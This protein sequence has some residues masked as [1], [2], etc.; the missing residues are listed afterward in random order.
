MNETQNIFTKRRR[1]NFHIVPNIADDELDLYEYRLYGHYVRVCGEQSAACSES[2]RATAAA[3]GFSVGA[4]A[5]VRRRLAEKGYIRLHETAEAGGSKRVTVELLDDEI[6]QR[7]S[8]D[9]PKKKG[10]P[11]ASVVNTPASVVNTPASVVNTTASV[12]N[13]TAS[14]VNTTALLMNALPLENEVQD[15]KDHKDHKDM[16]KTTTNTRTE[17]IPNGGGGEEEAVTETVDPLRAFAALLI[18][19]M[20][21][22]WN[23]HQRYLA[24]LDDAG[25][26]R[27]NTWLWIMRLQAYHGG[28]EGA[29][30]ATRI[31]ATYSKTFAGVTN[32]VAFIRAKVARGE[33]AWLDPQDVA[34]LQHAIQAGTL[35]LV[36]P[37]AAPEISEAA[38]LPPAPSPVVTVAGTEP[39][40]TDPHAAHWANVLTE[41]KLTMPV[42]TYQAWVHGAT[43]MAVDGA[44]WWIT[45]P[46]AQSLDWLQNRLSVKVGRIL[47]SLVGQSVN[48]QFC[49]PEAKS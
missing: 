22:T 18:T 6:W 33:G 12:V 48:V 23:G 8:A 36:Y 31:E 7:N 49:L 38:E 2:T 47:S 3:C 20:A 45:A 44:T 14:V 37:Q 25:V 27:L 9:Q 13:T 29:W 42:A 16:D 10:S 4:V 5:Q 46:N 24:G 34:A 30:I 32:H 15:H 43:V 1:S 21:P 41:L 35:D 40:A 11:A 19:T 26:A 28:M 39:A 17:A